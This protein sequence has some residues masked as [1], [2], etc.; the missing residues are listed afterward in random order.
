MLKVGKYGGEKEKK[1]KFGNIG[2]II[3]VL[4]SDPKFKWIS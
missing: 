3:I 2:G 4:L 1:M